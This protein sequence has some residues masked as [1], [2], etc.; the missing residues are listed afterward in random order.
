MFSGQKVEDGML[1]FRV[2]RPAVAVISP[3]LL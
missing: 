3:N 1:T 2:E